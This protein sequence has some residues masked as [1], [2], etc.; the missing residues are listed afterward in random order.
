MD[1]YP[2][3]LAEFAMACLNN[4]TE[5]HTSS[6]LNYIGFSTNASSINSW[7]STAAGNLMKNWWD[8]SPTAG[9]PNRPKTTSDV[10]LPVLKAL[11]LTGSTQQPTFP[12]AVLDRFPEA[13]LVAL[14]LVIAF[15]MFS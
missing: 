12:K 4:P 3:Q 15:D 14:V 10:K 7:T 2:N 6:F 13:Q 5:L 9:P 11:Q 1:L 8:S